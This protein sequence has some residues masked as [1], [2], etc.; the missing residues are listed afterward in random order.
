MSGSSTLHR[1]V[2][3][4]LQESE[5]A[6]RKVATPIVDGKIGGISIADVI[7]NKTA[8]NVVSQDPDDQATLIAAAISISGNESQFAGQ[9]QTY[10][11]GRGR[12][13]LKGRDIEAA[14][15]TYVPFADPSIG[16]TQM[17]YSNVTPQAASAVG[18][19]RPLD[20]LDSTKAIL[21]TAISLSRL[22]SRA[23]EVGYQTFMYGQ[24]PRAKEFRSTGN[25]ALDLAIAAYNG[26]PDRVINKFCINPKNP[27]GPRHICGSTGIKMSDEVVDPN[28]IPAYES[29][30]RP[31]PETDAQV[32]KNTAEYVARVAADLPR[33]RTAVRK[34]MTLTD[35]PEEP[36]VTLPPL[37][38][39]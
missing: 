11:T 35:V 32:Y 10:L 27:T 34:L 39:F 17:K 3:R 7:A 25:A 12:G 13:M 20:L 36:V 6:S 26:D 8:L 19:T 21:V 24:N 14:I 28:Y 29:G 38:D 30:E 16:P 15:A 5:D 23:Q 4:V 9:S 33:I 37:T 2:R 18:V 22:Y 31:S 1:I